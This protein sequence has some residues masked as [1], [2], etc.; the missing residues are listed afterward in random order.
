MSPWNSTLFVLALIIEG[1]AE[2]VSQFLMPIKS[3][4]FKNFV[5]NIKNVF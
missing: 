3:I 5:F 4:Y 2:K 1:A